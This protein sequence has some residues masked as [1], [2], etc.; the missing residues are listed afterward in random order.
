MTGELGILA[1]QRL[2]AWEEAILAWIQACLLFG[3]QPEW[4]ASLLLMSV[5]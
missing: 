1:A 2:Q 5:N 4:L 3:S